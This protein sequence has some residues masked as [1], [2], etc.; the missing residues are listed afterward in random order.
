MM[1]K[2]ISSAFEKMELLLSI[3]V[4]DFPCMYLSQKDK[5]IP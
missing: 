1:W 4:K 5:H 3:Q 2:Q